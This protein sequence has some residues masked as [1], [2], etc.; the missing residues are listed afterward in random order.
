M[1]PIVFGLGMNFGIAVDLAGRG[2]EDLG[3]FTRLASPSILIAPW[4]LVFVVWTGSNW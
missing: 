2:L 4:T 1:A 3:A